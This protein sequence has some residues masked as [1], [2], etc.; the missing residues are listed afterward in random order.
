MTAC[1]LKLCPI[2][3]LG[4]GLSTFSFGAEEPIPATPVAKTEQPIK[5]DGVLDEPAWLAAAPIRVNY[6]WGKTGQANDQPTMVVK[7]TWDDNYLYIGYETFDRN[8]VALGTDETQGPPKNQ[9]TGARIADAKEKVDVVEFFVSFGDERFFWELH[10]NAANQ[11]ND[12]W[13]AVVD[14][15]SPIS[16]Q[17][18]ARFGIYFGNREIVDDDTEAGITLASAARPKPKADGSPST[19]NDSSDTDTG[20]TAEL[21]LPW[22]GLG[23]PTERETRVNAPP[24]AAGEPERNIHGPW[25]MEGQE[26]L[27]LAVFQDGDLA[28]H[29][30]HSSPTFPG[31]WFHKGAAHYPHYRLVA[32]AK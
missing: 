20:Y 16:K 2:V 8:L 9:R 31:S 29:Y 15:A 25:K 27:V 7:Y 18:I 13:C 1:K 10:H 23:A 32:P 28:D 21:R 19:V 24:L 14:E 26:M 17:T 30:H 4:I 3:L 5:I 6:V 12:L 22:L 11:F